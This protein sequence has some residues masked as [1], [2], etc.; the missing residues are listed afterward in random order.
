MNKIITL[1]PEKRIAIVEPGVIT[2]K[3]QEK[4]AEYGLFYPPDPS[5]NKTCTIGGNIAEN[6]G[7]L[8]CLKYGVT[9]DYLLGTEFV[10]WEGEIVQ[11]GYFA[12]YPSTFDLT[13]LLCGSEGTLG[14][15]AKI[16]LKLIPAPTAFITLSLEFPSG[17]DAVQTVKEML[18]AGLCPCILEYIDRQTLKAI[19]KFIELAISPK[20][21][22]LL[23]IE[24]DEDANKNRELAEITSSIS[25]K[26][27][28]IILKTAESPE[29]RDL[30]WRLRRSISP[31]LTRLASGKIN[32]DVAV[33]RGCLEKLINFIDKLSQEINL[34]IP[35][36]GHAGDGNLHVNFIFE[37]NDPTQ[38]E[39]AYQGVEKVFKEVI[40]LGGSI[41][42]EHGIGLSKKNYLPLQLSLE[43][44][45]F[46]RKVKKCFDPYDILNP[47]KMF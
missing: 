1:N 38:V 14:V 20:T 37:R 31:S 10:D 2:F 23:L 4:A 21:Q 24:Y 8:R 3:L 28:A 5:S 13:T 6:A 44:F 27:N 36:Y 11:T 46:Q 26:H 39:S 22:A 47:G 12:E 45:V 17:I 40:R 25:K 30:L 18:D 7:G 41:S 35:I 15:I 16:A 33:P 9:A 43:N 32:E 42:G 19:T 29:E 34:P